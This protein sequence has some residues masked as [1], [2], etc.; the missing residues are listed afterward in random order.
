[1]VQKNAL[2]CCVKELKTLNYYFLN[3]AAQ[4]GQE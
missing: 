2:F 4:L 3:V 1:M